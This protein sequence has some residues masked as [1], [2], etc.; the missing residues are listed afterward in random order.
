MADQDPTNFE[1]D[2]FT[3]TPSNGVTPPTN[4][5]ASPQIP[6][7]PQNPTI[8][9][10]SPT[11]PT[12]PHTQDI[13]A[14]EALSSLSSTPDDAVT[15]QG[16]DIIPLASDATV[17]SMTPPTAS[18]PASDGATMSAD[19]D[20]ASIDPSQLPIPEAIPA[21]NQRSR[22][23]SDSGTRGMEAFG[24]FDQ[25]RTYEVSEQRQDSDQDFL[26]LI[27]FLRLRMQRTRSAIC[28]KS[29]RRQRRR[30]ST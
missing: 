2:K 8:T 27:H 26:M 5:L 4:I 1:N 11:L 24:Y 10:T 21:F 18:T 25:E 23:F 15:S 20:H 16:T 12:F 29:S 6:Q 3:L 30:P 7:N 19:T 14:E 17:P 28:R 9:L 13:H 22:T